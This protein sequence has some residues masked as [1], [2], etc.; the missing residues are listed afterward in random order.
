MS[1]HNQSTNRPP[2]ARLAFSRAGGA[3]DEGMTRK[4]AGEAHRAAKAYKLK[5][6]PSGFR[7]RKR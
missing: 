3:S 5:G 6:E 1:A 4:A 2:L 7:R